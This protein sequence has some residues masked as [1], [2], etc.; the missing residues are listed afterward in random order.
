MKQFI[1]M[2]S[3]FQNYPNAALATSLTNQLLAAYPNHFKISWIQ[4]NDVLTVIY[5]TLPV[6]YK[7]SWY[8]IPIELILPKT[9]PLHAP[10]VRVVPTDNMSIFV[11]N[12][13]HADGKV[14]L[15]YIQ[16]WSNSSTLTQLC[17]EM[18]E[19]FKLQPPV[20]ASTPKTSPGAKQSPVQQTSA[21]QS[22]VIQQP[23]QVTQYDPLQTLRDDVYYKLV[24]IFK[25]L[26]QDME[27]ELNNLRAHAQQVKHSKAGL[28]DKLNKITTII[29]QQLSQCEIINKE[30]ERLKLI[31]STKYDQVLECFIPQD[32]LGFDNIIKRETIQDTL[33]ILQHK[34]EN[35]EMKVDVWMKV[36][37][38]LGREQFYIMHTS[39]QSP[40]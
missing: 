39:T 24:P 38:Q 20:Y 21:H 9:F 14:I 32:P 16:R 2:N 1:W 29:Q 3:N 15:P 27:S 4:T 18:V 37:N 25:Q 35:K 10:L 26:K 30:I 17:L 8:N 22:P 23:I 31:N 28:H 36:V 7:K 33:D 40:K 11:S 12:N 13:V 6:P 19:I 5:G 34:F